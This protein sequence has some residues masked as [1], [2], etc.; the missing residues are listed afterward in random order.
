[1]A[2]TPAATV[3]ALRD[4]PDGLQV[5][6]LRRN[7]RGPFADM[8]VFPG[9][10]VDPVDAA[11]AVDAGGAEGAEID[12]ARRAAVREAGEE[13][14]LVL[15][16]DGLV[17][18][19]WWMPPATTVRPFATWFFL[20]AVEADAPVV[21]DGTEIV[22]HRWLAPAEALARRDE[23]EMD[24]VPPTWMTLYWLTASGTVAAAMAAARRQRPPRFAT[25]ICRVGDGLVAMWEGDAGYATGDPEVAGPRRRLWMVPSGWRAEVEGRQQ[26]AGGRGGWR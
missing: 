7:Q 9:G 18:L 10:Q 14:G 26:E 4:G 25:R 15:S 11:P 12:V 23:G 17:T 8:W 2:P 5:L 24:L 22:D 6:M 16:P 3:V 13:A 1:M 19:S 20:A 21:V